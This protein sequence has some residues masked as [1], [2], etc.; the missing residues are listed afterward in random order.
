MSKYYLILLCIFTSV[1]F[2]EPYD[3]FFKIYSREPAVLNGTVSMFNKDETTWL[4]NK[5]QIILAISEEDY[6]P[7]G[8]KYAY[9]STSYE[10]ITADIVGIISA[11]L[12]KEVIAKMYPSRSVALQALEK[13][14]VDFIGAANNFESSQGFNL[15]R[16][17]IEDNSSLYSRAGVALQDIEVLAVPIN[18]LPDEV[19]KTYFKDKKIV[20]YPSVYAAV[21]ST[22]YKLS[23]AVLVDSISANFLVNKLYQDSLQLL[24]LL[25]FESQGFTFAVSQD[26]NILSS[27]LNKAIDRI[28]AYQK[29]NI[30]QRWSGGGISLSN[31]RFT[32]SDEQKAYLENKKKIKIVLGNRVAPFSYVDKDGSFRGVV[33]DIVQGL[34]LSLDVD[35]EVEL[36][37][38]SLSDQ[39][40]SVKSG[41][42]DLTL[43]SSFAS[44][45]YNL[46][47]SRPILQDPLV[48]VLRKEDLGKYKNFREVIDAGSIA[49]RKGGVS[50]SIINYYKDKNINFIYTTKLLTCV[51]N[52][53]CLST[54]YP[55][56]FAQNMIVNEFADSLVVAGE[57]YDSEPIAI[58]FVSKKEN[59]VLVGIIN[60]YLSS[61][62]PNEIDLLPSRWRVSPATDEISISD[63]VRHYG[64]S[65]M[66]IVIIM[67]MMATLSISLLI[68]NKKRELAEKKLKQQLKFLGELVDSIPHPI[69]ARDEHG[70]LILCNHSF[71]SFLGT[72]END[73]IGSQYTSLPLKNE[74]MTEL[75]NIYNHIYKTGVPYEKDRK[76]LLSDGRVFHFYFWLHAYRDLLG[77]IA[78]VVGGWIDISERQ[79]LMEEL[80]EATQQ[81]R[82]ANRAKSTF[83]ANMSHEIRTPM[84]AIIGLLELTLRKE[85]INS[86]VKESLMVAHNSAKDLLALI[87][88]ILDI[89]KI[90]SEKIH[91]SPSPNNIAELSRSVLNVF[92]ANARE[93]GLSLTCTITDE[94]LVMVDPM[95]YKQI[96][97]NLISNAIKFTSEGSVELILSLRKETNSCLIKV[98]VID[99]GIGISAQDQKRLFQPFSQA[100]QP[101]DLQYSGTGLGLMICKSLCQMMGGSLELK[102]E[103]GKGTTVSMVLRLPIVE[104]DN[105]IRQAELRLKQE[106][107]SNKSCR[108]LLIDDHHANRM[109][110]TLQ[111]TFLGH[112]VAT[113]ESGLEALNLLQYEIFDIIITDINMPDINGFEFTIRYREK[114]I[115]EQRKRTVII[116]LTADAHQEQLEKAAAVGMDYCLFK[117]IGLDELKRC[118]S[119]YQNSD[120]NCD[121]IIG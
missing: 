10:G 57:L 30:Y 66:S 44:N 16:K 63:V 29:N 103:L 83:L 114:E 97:S 67:L 76:I 21:A 81:A 86:N 22:V 52:K 68:Q 43:L 87:G 38:G 41:E 112:K 98:D 11:I 109:L 3:G 117:P 48:Y 49:I 15:T 111:L 42:S 26:N 84:N 58:N 92:S 106:N 20:Y 115:E 65:L 70:A 34:R 62:P 32:L 77:N 28:S 93:K 72:S 120:N 71:S 78:G 79:K 89:S 91:L 23:D 6:P 94:Q 35:I 74:T 104:S 60:E 110:V 101:A 82:E 108:I 8:F 45:E 17:Y 113:A 33:A 116:G 18:Y 12:E 47:A 19:I 5:K 100:T 7:H 88:D 24:S 99:T 14:E 46:L 25:P 9:D 4:E 85:E 36:I 96:I 107:A 95:R 53:E 1:A 102:S 59:A 55:L 69:F 118:I 51:I 54:V 73:L 61:L 64:G 13:G 121:T 37:S 2:S 39:V 27:I 80:S 50:E 119:F 75:V 56:R 40:E 105:E 31:Y 90:E